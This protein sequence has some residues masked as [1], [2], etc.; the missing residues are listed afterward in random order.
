MLWKFGFQD[1]MDQNDRVSK[2]LLNF[3]KPQPWN[4][5]CINFIDFFFFVFILII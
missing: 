2:I 3:G 4:Q 5:E 1:R